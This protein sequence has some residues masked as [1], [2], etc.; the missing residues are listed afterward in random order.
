MDSAFSAASTLSRNGSL[1]PNRRATV[2]P[3]SFSGS[4]AMTV[5][6]ERFSTWIETVGWELFQLIIEVASGRKQT[7]SDRWGVHNALTL[8]NPGPVT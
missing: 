4:L 8:F 7:W 5:L 1:P 3:S 6:A 2:V